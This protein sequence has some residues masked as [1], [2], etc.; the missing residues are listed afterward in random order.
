M[1]YTATGFSNPVR[2]FFDAL[3]RP[4]RVEDTEET[5]AAHFR[6]AIKHS[7]EE[8]H[9]V[10]RLIFGVL[11]AHIAGATRLLARMHTGAS[12]LTSRMCWSR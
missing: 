6:V 10:D 5:V 7:R 8:V 3:F 2:V 4:R 1:I 12:M 11:V 9:I